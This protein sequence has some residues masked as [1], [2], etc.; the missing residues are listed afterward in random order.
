MLV[1]NPEYSSSNLRV[2]FLLS[3]VEGNGA[4]QPQETGK[5]S[6][7]TKY[8]VSPDT[9]WWTNFTESLSRVYKARTDTS[10]WCIPEKE[11]THDWR[12][13]DRNEA[14]G[15][16]YIKTYKASSS[17]C[18]GISLSIAHNVARRL[19]GQRGVHSRPCV[20]YNRHVFQDI[21]GLQ[22]RSASSLVWTM[23]RNPIERDLSSFYFFEVSRHP[24]T[25]VTDELLLNKLQSYKNFQTSYL[26]PWQTNPWAAGYLLEAPN[27]KT[28]QDLV[29]WIEKDIMNTYDFI[30]VTE[31]FDESLAV[32]VLLWN[33]EPTDVIVL[34]AKQS[35]GYDDAGE[36]GVCN[37]IV[38]PPP[39]SRRLEDYWSN[40][41]AV[42]NADFLLWEVANRSL[43][44]TIEK[45]GVARVAATVDEIRSLRQLAETWCTDQ[46]HFPCNYRG[47]TQFQLSSKS[48]YVQD[49]GCGHK[50]VDKV[51]AEYRQGEHF[52][53]K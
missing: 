47:E 24:D 12:L 20:H 27:N 31:R 18:E 44:R 17:T 43:D 21:G 19:Y 51:M 41:H 6:F 25:I 2:R 26:V 37:K 49:A 38:R 32:M 15:I 30:G 7:L 9:I 4:L 23:I 16:I 22:Y 53:V 50:C 48:C 35:G 5:V 10:T 8:K 29:G 52:F 1:D 28:R 46:A 45:L 42:D 14:D 36:T 40:E 13:N 39:S 33:L 11:P 34:S 3:K